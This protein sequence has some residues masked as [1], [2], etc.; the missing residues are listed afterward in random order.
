MRGA[1]RNHQGE[2]AKSVVRAVQEVPY[3]GDVTG[4]TYQL[5]VAGE[6]SDQVQTVFDGMAVTRTGGTTMLSG[7]VRDQAELQ[8]L[9]QRVSDFGLTLLEVKAAEAMPPSGSPS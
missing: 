4:R 7:Y 6:L 3:S 2:P 9:L 1:I 8:G 5:I